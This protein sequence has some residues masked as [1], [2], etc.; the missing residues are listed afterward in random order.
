MHSSKNHTPLVTVEVGSKTLRCSFI[1]DKVDLKPTYYLTLKEL[2]D[3]WIENNLE[4]VSDYLSNGKEV[5]VVNNLIFLPTNN[6]EGIYQI[7]TNPSKFKS[8]IDYF[9]NLINTLPGHLLRSI[10]VQRVDI[11]LNIFDAEFKFLDERLTVKKKHSFERILED[12][13]RE[14]TRTYGKYPE[15]IKFYDKAKKLLKSKMPPV[16]STAYNSKDFSRIEITQYSK[17]KLP[18]QRLDG[19]FRSLLSDS[20]NPFKNIYLSDY[21]LSKVPIKKPQLI[22][23]VELK[24]LINNNGLHYAS[25]LLNENHN[26]VRDYGCFLSD[27]STICFGDYYHQGIRAYLQNGVKDVH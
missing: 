3:Y 16:E 13:C 8:A 19:L 24:T 18:C 9:D 4:V 25:K 12:T 10:A 22:K 26:F 23:Y 27:K 6:F 14:R 11:A 17:A 7:L 15:V 5:L 21:E 2:K 1:I 20:Y